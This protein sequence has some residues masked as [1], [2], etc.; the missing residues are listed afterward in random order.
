MP[1]K[2]AFG[3][4]FLLLYAVIATLAVAASTVIAVK[5]NKDNRKLRDDKSQISQTIDNDIKTH[6]MYF[7][8]A[9]AIKKGLDRISSI[10]SGD[11]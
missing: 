11:E 10:A 5:A 2:M 4:S 9:P 8:L 6:K 1:K 7:V 3:F